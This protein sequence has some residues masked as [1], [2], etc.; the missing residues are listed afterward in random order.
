M[1]TL[2][3]YF[4]TEFGQ[5]A[6]ILF[7]M[8]KLDEMDFEVELFYSHEDIEGGKIGKILN[9]K[10][11]CWFLAMRC[12]KDF[13]K[14]C[15]GGKRIADDLMGEDGSDPSDEYKDLV[16]YLNTGMLDKT[17]KGKLNDRRESAM[18]TLVYYMCQLVCGNYV[19]FMEGDGMYASK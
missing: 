11:K 2:N 8:L 9:D 3:D 15:G 7:K 1:K 17:V 4:K 10:G 12:R 6:L 5:I 14:A 19:D 16:A 18:L 13:V